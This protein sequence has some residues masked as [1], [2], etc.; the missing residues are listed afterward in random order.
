MGKL[1]L[2]SLHMGMRSALVLATV[3]CGAALD[4]KWTPNGEA[5]LPFS[6]KAREQMG[7][8]PAAFAGSQQ[9]LSGGTVGLGLSSLAIISLTN[10]WN[11]V[12]MLHELVRQMLQPL[13]TAIQSKQ[14]QKKRVQ[15]A[16]AAEQARK[17]RLNRLRS[18]RGEPEPEAD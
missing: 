5:P 15:S 14:E 11:I 13:F 9:R 10:N 4:M 1:H 17:A 16:A 6:T 2:A 7:V 3:A 18:T 8:D 12:L